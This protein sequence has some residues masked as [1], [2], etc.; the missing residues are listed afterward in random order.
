MCVPASL[1]S[2]LSIQ[3]LPILQDPVQVCSPWNICACASLY[4]SLNWGLFEVRTC[5]DSSPK[6][7]LLLKVVSGWS[8]KPFSSWAVD[9]TVRGTADVWVVLACV[10]ATQDCPQTWWKVFHILVWPPSFA[11]S[12]NITIFLWHSRVGGPKLAHQLLSFLKPCEL[13]LQSSLLSPR[14]LGPGANV[15]L[16]KRT[17]A[18]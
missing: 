16:L 4:V 1:P 18:L 17:E 5:K 10:F 7:G 12:G 3:I 13:F 11:S 2:Q 9:T 8:L 6:C 14:W 15:E